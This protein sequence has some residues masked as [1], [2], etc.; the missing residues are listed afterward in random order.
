MSSR[1]VMAPKKGSKINYS[2]LPRTPKGTKCQC[3]CGKEV[4]FNRYKEVR[5][6]T[7]HNHNGNPSLGHSLAEL[8]PELAKEVYQNDPQKIWY[9]SGK[10]ILWKAECGHIWDETPGHRVGVLSM[11]K[12]LGCPYCSGARVLSGFNDLAITHPKISKEAYG[13]D[14]K[15]VS[16]GMVKKMQWK[17]PD[18]G[19]IWTASP[20]TR[21]STGQECSYCS[22]SKVW[23]GF[24][25]I[26]TTHP[27]LVKEAYDFDPTTLSKGSTKKV[28]WKCSSCE[29][30]WT[31]NPN[32]RTSPG[33]DTGCPECNGRGFDKLKPGYLYLM[34][35]PD[36]NLAQIGIT[37]YPQKRLKTHKKSGWYI[38]DLIALPSGV[39]TVQTETELKRWLRSAGITKGHK[40]DGSKFD[41]YTESWPVEE[42][43]V[44]SLYEICHY[45]EVSTPIENWDKVKVNI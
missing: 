17:C 41:G 3:P 11:G 34:C 18:Y 16:K 31:T 25:D 29:H 37:N 33:H 9:R 36:W 13:W 38:V 39:D 43:C 32:S 5:Y 10:K 35:Q 1:R 28:Q 22:G 40:P 7:G 14:P 20:N 4:P 45:A 30:I 8:Y 2:E 42:F 26:A 6:L 15:T 24:N 27:Q 44:T 23:P 12:Y 19:H 21:T